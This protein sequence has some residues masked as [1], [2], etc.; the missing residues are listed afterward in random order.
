MGS[1]GRAGA[2]V[3]VS[4]VLVAAAAMV[5]LESAPALAIPWDRGGA[6]PPSQTQEAVLPDRNCLQSYADDRPRGGP[7]VRFGIGPRPAG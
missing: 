2:G 5:G 6:I 7:R 1:H 3:T 4:A